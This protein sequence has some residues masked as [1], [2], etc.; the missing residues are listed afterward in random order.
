M[1]VKS[2]L[3]KIY[4][5]ISERQTDRQTDTDRDRETDRQ[6]QT[7]ADRQ[8]DRDRENW[9]LRVKREREL[10]FACDNRFA[11]SCCWPGEKIVQA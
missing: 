4:I 6:R 10:R 11:I 9:C 3:K 5:Y 2:V 1:K 8:T 7:E